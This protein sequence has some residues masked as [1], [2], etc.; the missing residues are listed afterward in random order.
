MF[1]WSSQWV[2]AKL[3]KHKQIY[4]NF[5]M[6][7]QI[8]SGFQ[9]LCILWQFVKTKCIFTFHSTIHV[10]AKSSFCLKNWL[11]TFKRK[12][13]FMNIT[14]CGSK[15]IF[16]KLF[17][18]LKWGKFGTKTVS[19]R[20]KTFLVLLKLSGLDHS[21]SWAYLW[22]FQSHKMKPILL[23]DKTLLTCSKGLKMCQD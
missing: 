10:V 4:I 23:S 14:P 12:S 3:F 8:G 22:L 6:I 20:K 19:K 5:A 21:T 11:L 16:S 13:D 2:L 9:F 7:F 1:V 15:N 18:I 17:C